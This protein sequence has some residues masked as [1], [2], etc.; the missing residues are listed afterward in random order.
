MTEPCRERADDLAA[1]ALDG[2]DPADAVAVQAHVD[3]C[4]ACAAALARLRATVSALDRADPARLGAAEPPPAGLDA[5]VLAALD[6]ERARERRRWIGLR[7]AAAAAV[8]AVA[9]AV[10]GAVLAV[11]EDGSVRT[12]VVTLA[13]PGRSPTGL[14]V[15]ARLTDRAWGT[16]VELVVEGSE[17][18][19]VYRVWLADERGQRSPAGTFRG[20]RQR[21]EVRVAAS[22][23]RPDAELIGV[24]TET[25][26]PLLV[27]P[28]PA[29]PAPGAAIR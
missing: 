17:P 22:L 18:G 2:L 23:S 3:G 26:D 29:Q 14:T 4:P 27:A 6:M 8:V 5:R 19:Q 11:G 7:G 16:A 1:L 13:A 25:D 15:S 24:S 9:A 21:L 10:V 28:L 12:E 20:V